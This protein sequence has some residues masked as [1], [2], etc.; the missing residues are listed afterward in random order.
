MIKEFICVDKHTHQSGRRE[1]E[2]ERG[3]KDHEKLQMDNVLEQ[4][5]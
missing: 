2:R 3:L 4:T 5:S 1:R